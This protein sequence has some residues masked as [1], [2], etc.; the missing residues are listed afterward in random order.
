MNR[1]KTIV[2]LA[3]EAGLSVDAYK[4]HI[5]EKMEKEELRKSE[6]ALMPKSSGW[7]PRSGSKK[8]N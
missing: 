5:K 6:A 2:E 4:R 7:N 8:K 3:R 1:K